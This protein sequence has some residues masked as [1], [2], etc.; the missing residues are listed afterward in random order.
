[1]SVRAHLEK[2]SKVEGKEFVKRYELKETFN[3]THDEEL[4]EELDLSELNE[5]CCGNLVIYLE[6]L[7]EILKND[8]IPEEQK[9]N[10]RKLLPKAEK[11]GCLV[12]DCY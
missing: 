3:L 9:I 12:F 7:Q 1:M 6:D 10:L 8:F 11:D 2:S 5:D 4:V